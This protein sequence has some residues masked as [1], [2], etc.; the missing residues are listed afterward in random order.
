MADKLILHNI[1][2]SVD[3]IS[4]WKTWTLHEVNQSNFTEAPKTN[5]WENIIRKLLGLV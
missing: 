2:P 4:V 5:G 3:K 1:T